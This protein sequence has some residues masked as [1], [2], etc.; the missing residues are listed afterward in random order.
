MSSVV[1]EDQSRFVTALQTILEE[2]FL[3]IHSVCQN[4]FST[5]FLK[6]AYEGALKSIP[7]MNTDVQ[8]LDYQG[9]EK[10]VPDFNG[11]LREA[12]QNYVHLTP[13]ELDV[14]NR[15][16]ASYFLHTFLGAVSDRLL[17]LL[18][19]NDL[20]GGI[21]VDFP[22]Q[23]RPALARYAMYRAMDATL[24]QLKK[25]G[26]L[27]GNATGS[28][29]QAS[30]RS[31]RPRPKV[32]EGEDAAA[33]NEVGVHLQSQT[34]KEG[35]FISRSTPVYQRDSAPSAVSAARSSR[36]SRAPSQVS[37]APSQVSRASRAPSQVSRAPSQ[38]SRA[39]SQASRVSRAPD[40]SPPEASEEDVEITAH[41]SISC[42]GSTQ[43]PTA[44]EKHQAEYSQRAAPSP[45]RE[46]LSVESL[47]EAAAPRPEVLS[48][49]SR[50]V[51]SQIPSITQSQAFRPSPSPHQPAVQT[52]GDEEELREDAHSVMSKV[53]ALGRTMA[54][55]S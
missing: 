55:S 33:L 8:E 18:Q 16:T 47:P 12:F 48:T 31:I 42:I 17:S 37:R 29:S 30:R 39:P 26:H 36:L 50:T 6:R 13:V 53:S 23:E 45:P 7:L 3:R 5:W 34:L 46:V 28:E 38:V 14:L 43:L 25:Q 11:L 9:A 35:S 10:T 24:H 52:T 21:L 54:A 4:Q 51:V 40:S 20:Y 2:Y 15:E 32:H 22:E 1:F 44:F 27:T 49:V 41:D 19:R